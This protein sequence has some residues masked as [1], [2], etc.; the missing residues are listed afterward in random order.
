MGAPSCC[1]ALARLTTG[2]EI[3]P[4]RVDLARTSFWKC[5]TCQGHVGCHEGTHQPLGTPATAE[6][7]AA[8]K[9]VHRVLDPIWQDAWRIRAYVGRPKRDR[10]RIQ[11]AARRR[12]YAYLAHRL[13][14]PREACHVGMFD[15]D[16]CAAALAVLDG[17]TYGAVRAWAQPI[18]AA[19]RAA[20]K[21]RPLR[22]RGR[23]AA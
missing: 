3:Y 5:D 16:R 17:L 12:L 13:G 20:G 10:R 23:A 15:L 6:V 4:H 2:R 19:A 1:G 21:P 9:A 18:E 8:R 7:R 14:I 11:C 22:E